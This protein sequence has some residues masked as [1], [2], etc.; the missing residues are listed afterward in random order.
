MGCFALPDLINSL[1]QCETLLHEFWTLGTKSSDCLVG[2][3]HLIVCDHHWSPLSKDE[4]IER[5]AHH[6]VSYTSGG[7]ASIGLAEPVILLPG[8]E[9][10]NDL[11][12]LLYKATIVATK[13]RFNPVD[14]SANYIT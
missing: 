2:S 10:L 7:V 5:L 11:R 8:S 14:E 4:L 9:G 12:Y 1:T 6:T 3:S 13:E